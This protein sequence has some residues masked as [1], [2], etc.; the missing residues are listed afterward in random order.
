MPQRSPWQLQSFAARWIQFL[1]PWLCWWDRQLQLLR[2]PWWWQL[3]FLALLERQ[4]ISISRPLVGQPAWLRWHVHIQRWMLDESE[5]VNDALDKHVRWRHHRGWC[6]TQQLFEW[7]QQQSF[8]S[9]LLFEWLGFLHRIGQQQLWELR[10]Q[11]MAKLD[12][13]N[14]DQDLSEVEEDYQHLD[15]IIYEAWCGQFV[16]LSFS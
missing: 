13:R 4:R 15:G 7:G 2:K 14:R 10:F 6:W 1:P 3:S 9:H 12:H 11:L 5:K 8:H 16:N